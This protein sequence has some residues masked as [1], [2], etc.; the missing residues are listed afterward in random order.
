MDNTVKIGSFL[1][2][3]AWWLALI[4]AGLLLVAVIIFLFLFLKTKKKAPSHKVDKASY[5]FALGGEDNLIEKELKGS[6]IVLK[7]KDYEAV[8]KEKLK[9]IGVDGFIMMSEKLTLV[10]KGDAKKVYKTLFGEDA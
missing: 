2:E 8:D 10:I 5:F 7:L 3:N 6:R 1:S 9:E 4:V